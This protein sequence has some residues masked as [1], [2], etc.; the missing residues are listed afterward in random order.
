MLN[1]SLDVYTVK[2][3]LD[4][5]H[6]QP[7]DIFTSSRYAKVRLEDL[8]PASEVISGRISAIACPMRSRQPREALIWFMQEI[9]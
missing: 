3:L 2:I 5:P 7:N 1:I 9:T 4:V 8:L 6:V